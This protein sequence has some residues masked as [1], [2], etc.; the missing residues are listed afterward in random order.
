MK[1]N[2]AVD[3]ALHVLKG[4]A[5]KVLGTDLT[6]GVFAEGGRG[7]LTVECAAKPSEGQM[8]EI[9]RLAN[10]KIEEDA[11]IER[12][13][14]DRNEAEA[15]FGKAIYDRFPVPASVRRLAIARIEGWNVNCCLGP[16]L[17]T[18]GGIGRLSIVRWRHRLSRN[19]LEISFEI[20]PKTDGLYKADKTASPV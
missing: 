15:A 14:M 10:R 5:Q 13:D 9:E 12:L 17:A 3:S 18:T 4:A 6:T 19:E 8:A 16:H 20:T 1:P 11:P 7:R 2:P